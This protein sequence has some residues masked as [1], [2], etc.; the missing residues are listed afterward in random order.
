MSKPLPVIAAVATLL[1]QPAVSLAQNAGELPGLEELTRTEVLSVSRR[2]Q[3]VSNVPAAAFVITAED[4]R[5][6]GALALP[7]VLRM[8]PGVQVAQ[9]DSSRYAVTARG[10]NGRFA[11]KLQVL[12]DGRS[13]FNP[14]FSGTIWE[15]DPIPLADIER[16]EVLRGP[17]AAMWGANAVNGVIN[18]VSKSARQALG[19]AL[20]ATYGSRDAGALYLRGGA[21]PDADSAWKLSAQLR[22]AEPSTLHAGGQRSEDRLDNGVVDFR[23]DQSMGAGR[24]L[25]VWLNAAHSQTGD[26]YPLGLTTTPPFALTPLAMKQTVDSQS[27][28]ARY[29]WLTGSGVESSLQF[30]IGGSSVGLDGLF[31][32]SH[33]QIDID[34]QGRYTAGQHDLLWGISHR[35]V[36]DEVSYSN[37]V[38]R[39]QIF[40]I[41]NDRFTQDSTG[42]FLHDDWAIMPDR[43]R[44]GVGARLDYTNLGGVSF[45]PNATLMWT[46]SATATF[47]TRLSKAPRMPARA[48]QHVTI[49]TTYTPPNPALFQPAVLTRA[50]PGL[51][52]LRQETA[53]SIEMGFRTQLTPQTSI[54]LSIYRSRYSDI[55]SSRLGAQHVETL[56]LS[57]VP[58]TYVVQD[59]DRANGL[60]GW[61]NGA[62]LSVDWLVSAAWRLQLSYAWTQARMDDSGNPIAQAQGQAIERGTPRHTGSLRSQ[63]NLSS[64]QQFDVWLRGVSGFERQLA[65]YTTTQRV[66]GYLTLDLRYAYKLTRDLELAIAGRNLLGPRRIEYVTDY[67]PASPVLIGPS[68][69]VT[70]GWKF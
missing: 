17:G 69:F 61:L 4:I 32:E 34:Y 24:D 26:R 20:Q 43:I 63:W 52:E 35:T 2:N 5:R 21:A 64:R 66:P 25:S 36:D 48:E 16:I 46:P 18:I 55:V 50:K 49:N 9:I 39:N 31:E 60:N 7:D 19:G 62:E 29:R 70:A 12:V 6:S 38:T 42:V 30:S 1:A 53:K 59:L 68:F 3:S 65:P 37:T 56:V 54:D 51:S 28:G 33:R 14:F 41:A 22:H 57:G 67:V 44:L 15:M 58:I 45:S 10:F 13:I 23:Y 40:A 27:L 11:N 8:V 47:W